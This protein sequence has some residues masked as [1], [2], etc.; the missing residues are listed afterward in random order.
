MAS[1]YCNQGI[2]AIVCSSESEYKCVNRFNIYNIDENCTVPPLC[3]DFGPLT[4]FMNS[5]KIRNEL[6]SKFNKYNNGNWVA[7]NPQIQF[8]MLED[9]INDAA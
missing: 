5:E 7:C 4:K 2:E 1:S 6:K 8:S 9:M 3:Y